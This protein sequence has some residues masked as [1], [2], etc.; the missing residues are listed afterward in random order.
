MPPEPRSFAATSASLAL[1]GWARAV[2]K[3]TGDSDG[4]RRGLFGSQ[5]DFTVTRRFSVA[6]RVLCLFIKNAGRRLLA[7]PVQGQPSCLFA[8][9]S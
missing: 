4:K 3:V 8:G 9:Y 1:M 6:D 2:K 5:N 7:P